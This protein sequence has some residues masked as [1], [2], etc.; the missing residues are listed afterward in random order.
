[1]ISYSVTQR[2]AEI[3]IRMALGARQG[4]ILASVVRRSMAMVATGIAAGGVAAFGLSTYLKGL[5]F[6]ITA[7]DPLT[8][9]SLT[10][11]LGMIGLA[12][13]W[14]PARRAAKLDPALTLRQE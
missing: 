14:I 12:A 6:A 7:S 1:V 3:G 4:A 10:L 2:T 5:L 11:F 9:A 13:C 8:Y